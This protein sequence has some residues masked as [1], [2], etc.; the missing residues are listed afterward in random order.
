MTAISKKFRPKKLCLGCAQSP[1]PGAAASGFKVCRDRWRVDSCGKAC[2]DSK[3]F[4]LVIA[5]GSQPGQRHILEGQ[6]DE[7]L[8]T[9]AG[10]L[11][12]VL[13]QKPHAR[14]QRS[15]VSPSLAVIGL[16]PDIIKLL[17][18]PFGSCCPTQLLEGY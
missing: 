11:V 10:D 14:L 13:Q 3:T 4:H 9:L 15:G 18:L 6:G 16:Q 1:L 2:S 17:W 8:D 5:R 7:T 12:F